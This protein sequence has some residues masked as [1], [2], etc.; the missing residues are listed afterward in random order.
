MLLK[1]LTKVVVIQNFRVVI[2]VR[3]EPNR[4]SQ[5]WFLYLAI[6]VLIFEEPNFY[7][8]Q[9]TKPNRRT[10]RPVLATVSLS[11]QRCAWVGVFCY[12]YIRGG[13]AAAG[14][15]AHS[16]MPYIYRDQV[17]L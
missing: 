2:T 9:R 16:L 11:V 8:N 5:F 12:P 3:L 1:F 13:G 6:L 14:A 10:K 15:A 4:T 7:K 17:L